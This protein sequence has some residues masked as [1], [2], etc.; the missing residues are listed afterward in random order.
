MRWS[1]LSLLAA[2]AVAVPLGIVAA[3]RPA[4][5]RSSLG[6]AGVVQTIPSLALLVFM[7]PLLGIGAPPAIAALFLYSLLP[8]V[9]NTHAG[10]IGIPRVAARVGRGARPAARA[11]GCG[12]SSCRWRRRSILAGIKTRR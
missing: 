5:G 1:A 3:R 7:I 10:L 9:R 4:L 6:A 11:R 2:I 8:I 12:S